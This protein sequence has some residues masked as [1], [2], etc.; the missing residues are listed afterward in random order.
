MVRV[1]RDRGEGGKGGGEI[2]G[3]IGWMIA[4]PRLK[5]V[6]YGVVG[7]TA[8]EELRNCRGGLR[9]GG[10]RWSFEGED[11]LGG[12]HVIRGYQQSKKAKSALPQLIIT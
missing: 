7:L 10:G 5:W 11:H 2:G 3:R 6:N 8:F 4:Q 12:E 1:C 9:G